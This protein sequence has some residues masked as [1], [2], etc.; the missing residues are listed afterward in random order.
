MT[1][2]ALWFVDKLSE[3]ITI[4]KQQHFGI[5][6]LQYRNE[7]SQK[8]FLRHF[9]KTLSHHKTIVGLCNAG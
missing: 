6:E 4:I 5:P 9:T 8:S 3:I 2:P 1:V 7:I